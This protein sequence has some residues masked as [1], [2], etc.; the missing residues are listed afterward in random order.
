MLKK[1]KKGVKEIGEV[2][3]KSVISATGYF[4]GINTKG[5]FDVQLKVKFYESELLNALQFVSGIGKRIKMLAII[6]DTKIQIGQFTVFSMKIDRD[7]NC[8]I[9]FKSNKDDAFI[10]EFSKLMVDECSITIKAAILK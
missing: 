2:K 7:A 3:S 1:E 8:T 5:N 9:V 4:D 6:E 10:D